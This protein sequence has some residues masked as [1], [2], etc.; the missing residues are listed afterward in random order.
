MTINGSSH[1]TKINQQSEVDD[2]TQKLD[3]Q[4]DDFDEPEIR[5]REV[6]AT[7]KHSLYIKKQRFVPYM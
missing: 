7:K 4:F 2:Q 1:L 3:A 6:D 5:S